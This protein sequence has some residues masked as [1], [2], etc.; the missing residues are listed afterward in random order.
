MR[1]II[2]ALALL[3]LPISLQAQGVMDGLS[4]GTRSQLK[5]LFAMATA[6][7]L[8]TELMWKQVAEGQSKGVAE[9]QILAE[10]SRMMGQL[11]AAR[12]ALLRVGRKEVPDQDVSLGAC[13]LSRGATPEQ[14]ET[15]AGK[16]A[17]RRPLAVALK[18]VT[19]LVDQGLP[20]YHA[21]QQVGA[22]LDAGATDEQL[23]ALKNELR[24]GMGRARN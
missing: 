13:V 16:A 9:G 17:G 23:L 24:L 14:L 22:R 15:M 21:L 20:L 19:T 7:D 2:L 12:S 1:R 6:K 18:V 10:T 3:Q 5:K 11:E 8:P 4:P